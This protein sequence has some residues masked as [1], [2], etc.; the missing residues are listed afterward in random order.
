MAT[1]Q[2]GILAKE[3]VRLKKENLLLKEKYLF[4]QERFKTLHKKH[5]HKNAMLYV[6]E[7]DKETGPLCRICYEKEFTNVRIRER[8]GVGH[9]WSW[10]CVYC[11]R[12]FE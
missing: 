3:N 10:K 6:T 2:A 11:G 4:L 9:D 5:Y 8:K 1:N 12:D 7:K